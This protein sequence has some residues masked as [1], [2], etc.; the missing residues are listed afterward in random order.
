MGKFESG[1]SGNPN[2]RPKGSVSKKIQL[3][4]LLEPHAEEL[5]NKVAELAKQG[6]I[7]ALKICLDRL[8]PKPKEATVEFELPTGD[9]SHSGTLLQLGAKIIQSVA[10]GE[11]TISESQKMI[12]LIQDQCSVIQTA[13]LQQEIESIKKTLKMN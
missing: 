12:Q 10:N 3:S 11:L 4:K 8:I 6:E 7:N 1:Q 13:Q 2:G 5:V 9:L